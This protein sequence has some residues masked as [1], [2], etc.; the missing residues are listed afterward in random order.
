MTLPLA[1]QFRLTCIAR[2]KEVKRGQ[3][4]AFSMGK[5]GLPKDV[6]PVPYD[7]K[8]LQTF[9]AKAV[10]VGSEFKMDDG[11]IVSASQIVG[12]DSSKI[13]AGEEMEGFLV[14][15]VVWGLA[16]SR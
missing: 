4:V 5:K 14:D 10:E 16:R 12:C 7:A 8:E 11:K 2:G 15:N 6:Q 13:K 1:I 3:Y 9:K